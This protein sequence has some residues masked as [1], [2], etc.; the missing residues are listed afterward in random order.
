M[1]L[2]SLRCIHNKAPYSTKKIDD[3]LESLQ[4]FY[5]F[6]VKDYSKI[7]KNDSLSPTLSEFDKK[8]VKYKVIDQEKKLDFIVWSAGK[9]IDK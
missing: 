2:K 5:D 3:R 7:L 9:L 1:T 4:S 6:L 8:F